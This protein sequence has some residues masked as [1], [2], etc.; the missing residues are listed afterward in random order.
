MGFLASAPPVTFDTT[1]IDVGD[2][3]TSSVALA[4]YVVA[5]SAVIFGALTFRYGFTA[6]WGAVKSAL[7]ITAKAAKTGSK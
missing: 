4:V 3:M 6:V 1:P 5:L 7:G 2:V